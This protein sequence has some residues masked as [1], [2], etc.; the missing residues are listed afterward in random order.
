M[1]N[2]MFPITECP[3]CGENFFVVRQKISGYGEYVVDMRNGEVDSTELHDGLIYRNTREYAVCVGC[4][5]RL[6]K[7]DDELNVVE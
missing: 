7:I 5:K 3:N 1:R 2:I 6:F 4:G